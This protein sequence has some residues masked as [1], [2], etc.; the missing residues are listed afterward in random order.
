MKYVFLIFAATLSQAGWADTVCQT[1]SRGVPYTFSHYSYSYARDTVYSNCRNAFGSDGWECERNLTCNEY[2]GYPTQPT[3]TCSTE[4]NGYWFNQSSTDGN[5]ASQ[6]VVSD[7]MSHRRTDNNECRN[8]VR[9]SG[10]GGGGGYNP[11]PYNPP[12]YNPPP[13]NPPPSGEYCP[14]PGRGVNQCVTRTGGGMAYVGRIPMDAIT[15]CVNGERARPQGR[16]FDCTCSNT[17]CN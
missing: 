4:S 6:Q 5:W 15:Q 16:P 1:Y 14:T 12:P 13:Y 9:C 2:S 8:N 3:M 11:P 7:C 10:N 17:T